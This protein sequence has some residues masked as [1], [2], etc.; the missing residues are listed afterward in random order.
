MSQRS[1][2]R[3]GFTLV[4]LLVVIAIIGVLIAL[5]LPAVQAAR[6]A[7]RRSQCLNNLKQ[8]GLGIQNYEDTRKE[9]CP[10][11]LSAENGS[12]VSGNG[13]NF[14]AWPVLLMPFMEQTNVYELTNIRVAMTTDNPGAPLVNGS[15][16]TLRE[17]SIPTYFCPSRRSPPQLT[18]NPANNCTVGDYA[19]VS[20]TRGTR[21]SGAGPQ[22]NPNNEKEWDGSM[23]PSRLFNTSANSL[24]V[25]GVTLGPADWRSMTTFAS[26]LDG[27]SNTAIV[28][29]KAVHKDN[30][31]NRNWHDGPYYYAGGDYNGTNPNVPGG[32]NGGN[33][34]SFTRAITGTGGTAFGLSPAIPRKPTGDSACTAPTTTTGNCANNPHNRFGSW[35]P[36]VTLF[37]LGDGSVRPVN[38]AASDQ[39]LRRFGC[40][41]DRLTFDLP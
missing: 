11:Y 29:E 16:R 10:A 26:I 1:N 37:L 36:G 27:L 5:L 32:N 2:A 40:R 20:I 22:P 17:T 18:T 4:E 3:R 6:E 31:G 21:T 28:G 19:S 25:Q 30:L 41:N 34:A 35:H 13:G 7:A 33:L 8:I 9:M 38:N 23:L 12:A 15:H 14:A 24:A 39:T